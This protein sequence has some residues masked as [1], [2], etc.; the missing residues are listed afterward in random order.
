MGFVFIYFSVGGSNNDSTRIAQGLIDMHFNLIDFDTVSGYFYKENKL[1]IYQTLVTFIVSIFTANPQFLFFVF[2]IVFGYFYSRNMFMIFEFAKTDKLNW[3]VWAV[4]LMF[5]LI[6][7]IWNINGV[8][9]YTA[10]HVFLYGLYSYLLKKNYKRLIW[11]VLSVFV[12]FSF[13]IPLTLLFVY[14]FLPKKNTSIFFIFYFVAIAFAEIDI[15]SLKSGLQDILPE[16]LS[17]KTSDYMSEDYVATVNELNASYS[18]YI[19]IAAQMARYFSLIVII[20]FWINIKSLFKNELYVKM[21]TLFLFFGAIF[22]ILSVIP[23]MG[24]FKVITNMIF[25]ALL[26]I[27]LFDSSE[28]SKLNLFIKYSS[29]LLILPILFQLRKGTDFYGLSLLWGNFVS[30]FFYEDNVTIIEAIKSIIS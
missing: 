10:F 23:S 28:N 14:F 3:W 15:Q 18:Q 13:I 6:V 5:I 29:L 9:M 12:H 19:N 26:I 8:R 20:Y 11:C 1:D 16:Q 4:I 22:E 25:Y 2:A 24:R 7:P 21:L 27:M 30:A 17:R